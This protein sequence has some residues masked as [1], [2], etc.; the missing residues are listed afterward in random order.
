MCLFNKKRFA[1][2]HTIA[3]KL[4]E[5]VTVQSLCVSWL[6]ENPNLQKKK[7]KKIWRLGFFFKIGKKNHLNF[8]GN[9]AE[10]RPLRTQKIPDI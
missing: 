10:F 7:H 5:N 3:I 4:K 6:N 9:G 2:T 1:I 8:I